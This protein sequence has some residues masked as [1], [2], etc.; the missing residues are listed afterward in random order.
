VED[1]GDFAHGTSS[2]TKFPNFLEHKM[3]NLKVSWL[4]V[5]VDTQT[6]IVCQYK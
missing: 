2:I 5:T 3:Q 6:L 4:Y 1:T